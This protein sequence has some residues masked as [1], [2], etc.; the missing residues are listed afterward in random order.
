MNRALRSVRRSP[1]KS[2]LRRGTTVVETAVVLPVFLFLFLAII[3]FGH[4][5]MVANILNSACRVGARMGS[6]EGVSTADITARVNQTL[7]TAVDPANVSV[8]VKDASAFDSAS[9]P[10]TTGVSIEALPDLEVDDAEPRQ[11]FVVRA[12]VAYNDIALVPMDFMNGVVLET[13][14]FIRHE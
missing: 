7:G 3:E 9:P 4:A 6:T 5:Q 1:E 8:F 2:P 11:M 10:D 14:A 12:K 13:Q